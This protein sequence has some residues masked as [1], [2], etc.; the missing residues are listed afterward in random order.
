MDTR[1]LT[2]G[3]VLSA[4]LL[5]VGCG[6]T[7]AGHGPVAGSGG[8][9]PPGANP[10]TGDPGSAGT[11]PAG[12][13]PR[14]VHVTEVPG[15]VL[16]PQSVAVYGDS[17]FQAVYVSAQGRRIHLGVD[18]GDPNS[19]DCR[20]NPPA[21]ETCVADGTAW[22]RGTSAEHT[23]TRAGNGM[24]VRVWADPKEI[25]RATLYAALLAARPAEP[26]AALPAPPASGTPAPRSAPT[27]ANTPVERGDLPPVGDGAP[28][29][30]PPRAG[31]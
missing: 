4:A 21:G 1:G 18:A 16:A 14:F 29:N 24:V 27:T 26:S 12:V 13:E 8:P 7:E 19:A 17:G 23:Y 31:G 2:A 30:H 9:H 11:P 10:P 20:P 22:Y 5:L 3:V 28:L 15:Y 6:S 25:D